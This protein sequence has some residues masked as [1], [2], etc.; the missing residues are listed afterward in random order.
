MKDIDKSSLPFMSIL[1][2][3]FITL[4]LCNVITW[5]WVFVLAPLWIP[6]ALACS[7]AVFVLIMTVVMSTWGRR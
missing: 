5:S 7:V 4:K 2:L 3:I 1:A 6:L